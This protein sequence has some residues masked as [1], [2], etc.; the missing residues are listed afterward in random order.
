MDYAELLKQHGLKV[1][2]QR[3]EIIGALSSGGHVS[4]EELYALMRVKFT[5]ISLATIY[6][7]INNMLNISLVSE[8]KVADQ[9]SLY[10]L[11]KSEHSHVVCSRCSKIEDIELDTDMLSTQAKAR[12]GFSVSRYSIILSGICSSCNNY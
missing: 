6:K 1:T 7:N 10:E 8:V 5:S 2:P 12:S 4:I 11:T 3:L 9:K